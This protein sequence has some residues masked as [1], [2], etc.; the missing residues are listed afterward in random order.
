MTGVHRLEHV[1]RFRPAD[2]TDDDAVR[3]HAQ[4]VTD[5]VPDPDLT[6]TLGVRRA[7]F[8][9]HDVRLLQL[10]LRRILDR[11][12]AL[13]LGDEGRQHV[14]KRRLTGTGAARDQHVELAANRR[15]KHVHE[16]ERERSEVDQILRR[17]WILG[18]LPDRQ[19]RTP[20]GERRDDRVHT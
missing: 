2:L 3:A 16:L 7:G 6:A 18:E 20:E 13:A 15:L 10:K 9:A 5:Q 19:H 12:D 14:E 11:D 4:G 1:E 8:Q 17:E